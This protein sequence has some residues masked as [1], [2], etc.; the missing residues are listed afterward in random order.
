[1]RTVNRIQGVVLVLVAAAGAAQP[2]SAQL[3]AASAT[4]LGVAGNQTA[5]ARGLAALSVNPAGL[6][7]PGSGFTL[8]VLPVQ[9]RPGI[10]PITAGDLSD[11]GGELLPKAVA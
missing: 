4:T 6:G 8:A 3:A 7:M 5:S 1:M 2:A 11:Y 10:D 9:V